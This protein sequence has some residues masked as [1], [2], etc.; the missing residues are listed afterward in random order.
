M[1]LASAVGILCV[2]LSSCSVKYLPIQA[3]DVKITDDFAIVKSNEITFAVENKF[4]IKEP[5]NLTDYFTTFYVSI[6]NNTSQK[7]EIN[8]HDIVLLDEYGNQYD[9]VSLDYIENLLLPKQIEFLYIDTIEQT[10]TETTDKLQLLEQQKDMLEKWREAKK[11]LITY[12]L[13][14]GSLH[15]GA[16]KSGFIFFPR[17]SSQNSKCKILFQDKTIEFIRSDV[18]KKL[19]KG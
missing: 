9:V 1:I 3:D 4:W 5:Q 6:K 2:L 13:H 11:N 15:P 14:F 7:L 16:Q 8:Q 17:L 19:E 18:K 12:S 10:D